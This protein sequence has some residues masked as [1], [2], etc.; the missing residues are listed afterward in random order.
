MLYSKLATIIIPALNE[1]K[2]IGKCLESIKNLDTHNVKCEVMLVDNGSCDSTCEIAESFKGALDL[3]IIVVKGV[4]IA[5]L[6]NIGAHKANG[7]ILAFL[8]ADCTVSS[9]WLD[10]A[11]AYFNDPDIAA[12]GSSHQIPKC[13]SW[14][15]KTWDLI[16]EK[17]RVRMPTDNLPSGNLLVNK[18]IFLRIGGFDNKLATNEDFDLCF[19]L[20]EAGYKLFSDP[21]I[22][23][24]HWG[25]PSK[26]SEFYKRVKW[27]GRDVFKVFFRNIHQLNNIRAILYG[28]YYFFITIGFLC[29]ILIFPF[30]NSSLFIIIMGFALL[31]PA[32]SLSA[33]VIIPQKKTLYFFFTLTILYLTYGFARAHSM[34]DN[35]FCFVKTK[36]RR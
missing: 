14:V 9:S 16:V 6:R 33:K 13:A 32:L 26:L 28:L 18:K 17:K 24:V 21:L 5:A 23:A 12:V 3:R 30:A 27:H 8:D 4:N 34:F 2:Y 11:F 20:K 15:A 35:L 19:R 25:V 29:S 22:T 7:S 1:E 31:F 36:S 10:N